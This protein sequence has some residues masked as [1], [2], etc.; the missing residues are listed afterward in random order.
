MATPTTRQALGPAPGVSQQANCSNSICI[1]TNNSINKSS[2]TS[3][4]SNSI[5]EKYGWRE[6]LVA[7]QSQKSNFQKPCLPPMAP[8]QSLL[9]HFRHMNHFRHSRHYKLE[10]VVITQTGQ[11]GEEAP[12]LSVQALVAV[13]PPPPPPPHVLHQSNHVLARVTRMA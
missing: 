4:A 1:N 10:T 3:T 7:T 2:K 13:P 12:L 11:Q 5:K 6:A 9:H 8:P